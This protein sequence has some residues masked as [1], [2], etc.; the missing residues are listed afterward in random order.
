M[1]GK[2]KKFSQGNTG[3]AV[4]WFSL[5]PDEDDTFWLL[6]RF[7][8]GLGIIDKVADTKLKPCR[9]SDP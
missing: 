7:G 2:Q 6:V 5:D 9:A 4:S 3:K 8:L 1:T